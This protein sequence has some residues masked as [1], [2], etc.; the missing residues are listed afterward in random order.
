MVP[1]SILA[2]VRLRVLGAGDGEGGARSGRR[3]WAPDTAAWRPRTEGS[4]RRLRA[5]EPWTAEHKYLNLTETRRS[6][7]AFWSEQAYHRLRRIKAAVDPDDV[8][9]SHG[10]VTDAH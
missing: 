8:I 9:R 3:L 4:A 5:I 6:P 10:Q 7:G 2:V 1:R